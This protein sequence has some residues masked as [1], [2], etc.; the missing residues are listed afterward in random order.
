M[1]ATRAM[2]LPDSFRRLPGAVVTPDIYS[3]MGLEGRD[4]K[5][6]ESF[7]AVELNH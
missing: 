4:A 2:H 7:H 5:L 3:H 1:T 6:G